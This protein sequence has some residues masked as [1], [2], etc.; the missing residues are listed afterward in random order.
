MG[1]V[2]DAK[3]VLLVE[4]DSLVAMMVEDMLDE[5]GFSLHDNPQSVSAALSAVAK[6]GFDLAVLDLNLAGQAVFPVAEALDAAR[7]PFIFA[8]GYGQGGVPEAWAGRPVAAKPFR[9]EDLE[10][11]LETALAAQHTS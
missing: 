11:V 4:D 6:G 3:R 9:I 8:S 2:T 1:S 7:I 10:A 5:L